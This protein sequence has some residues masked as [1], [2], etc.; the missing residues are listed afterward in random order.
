FFNHR[1]SENIAKKTGVGAWRQGIDCSLCSLPK[2]GKIMKK[3]INVLI[4]GCMLGALAP[5]SF[6]TSASGGLAVEA[7]PALA[8]VTGTVSDERGTPLAGA[9][10]SVLEP[11]L[12]G[13]ELKSAR[14]DGQGK[15]LAGVVPG[16]YF[17]R[18][19]AEGFITKSTRLVLSRSAKTSYDFALK[20][21]N[22]LVQ[23]RG[24]S[25]NYRWISLSAPGHV[26]RIFEGAEEEVVELS[27]DAAARKSLPATHSSIHGMA[28]FVAVTSSAPAGLPAPD[29]FGTNFAVSG[30]LGGNFEMAFIGQ[31][32][33]GNYAPQR[34]AAVATVRPTSSPQVTAMSAYGP[35]RPPRNGY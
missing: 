10:V 22:T 12:R 25:D 27:N 30:S 28:Q 20:T 24:D 34:L 5:S 3:A 29:F 4:A 1:R 32:G 16:A 21:D 33:V 17:I 7:S 13:K 19:M 14:T 26:L 9:T 31:R 8:F 2:G 6:N 15:F 23:K 18:A 35:T 11:R